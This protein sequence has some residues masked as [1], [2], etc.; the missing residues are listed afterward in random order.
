MTK[1]LKILILITTLIGCKQ[2]LSKNNQPIQDTISFIS[3][4]KWNIDLTGIDSLSVYNHS[5]LYFKKDYLY[6]HNRKTGS[7]EIKND[8]LIVKEI[9]YQHSKDTFIRKENLKLIAKILHINHDSLVLKKLKGRGFFF[10]Y[11]GTYKYYPNLDILRFYND[12]L[13][14]SKRTDF[15]K[16]SLSSSLCYG[17]CPSQAIEISSNGDYKF[18]GGKYSKLSGHYYGKL[19]SGFIDTLKIWLTASI[20][21]R[22]NLYNIP[23]ID[24]PVCDI[25]IIFDNDSINIYGCSSDFPLRLRELY[26]LIMDSYVRADLRKT[27]KPIEFETSSHIYDTIGIEPPPP[28]PI[29]NDDYF[30]EDFE[31]GID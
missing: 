1:A 8:T 26:S 2:H 17:N 10:V 23:P 19:Q 31:M 4:T 7:Y 29:H 15:N 24:A 21:N 30:M 3:N 25:K 16:I 13:N 18:F 5:T 27:N 11:G 14:F 6:F 12:T 20:I 28:P 9:Y 22:E